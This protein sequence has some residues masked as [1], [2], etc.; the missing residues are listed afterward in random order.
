[1]EPLEEAEI[2]EEVR[3]I[4]TSARQG[5]DIVCDVPKGDMFPKKEEEHGMVAWRTFLR[6][7]KQVAEAWYPDA[8]SKLNLKLMGQKARTPSQLTASRRPERRRNNS[9]ILAIFS[10][11]GLPSMLSLCPCT[12]SFIPLM[13]Q[14]TPHPRPPQNL[15]N[16]G[17]YE[18]RTRD[19]S[20]VKGT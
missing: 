13:N 17:F 19:L 3:S 1:M 8:I 5:Q 10:S 15:E 11:I 16:A 12:L 14:P 18:D 20:R 6:S 7:H 2:D 4:W 9:L